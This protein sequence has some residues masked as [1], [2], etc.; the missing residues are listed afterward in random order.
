MTWKMK[1]SF[2]K[3]RVVTEF[4]RAIF[5]NKYK[6][7]KYRIFHPLKRDCI[8]TSDFHK[9]SLPVRSK[10]HVNNLSLPQ[11]FFFF[12]VKASLSERE[13]I[14]RQI[15]I[16]EDRS[17][18]PTLNCKCEMCKFLCLPQIWQL[19]SWS[20]KRL[21]LVNVTPSLCAINTGEVIVRLQDCLTPCFIHLFFYSLTKIYWGS[22]VCQHCSRHQL[23]NEQNKH[24]LSSWNLQLLSVHQQAQDTSHFVVLTKWNSPLVH[25]QICLQWYVLSANI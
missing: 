14:Y 12:K 2:A 7:K 10:S 21:D 1:S 18:L 19:S 3:H 15:D 6:L 22:T 25:V 16:S 4:F 23:K 8:S 17:G 24:H 5:D 20:Q 13:T 9:A 11:V